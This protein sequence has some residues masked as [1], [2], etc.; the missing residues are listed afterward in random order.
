M[1]NNHIG[2]YIKS[3]GLACEWNF[4]K[5]LKEFDLTSVQLS[6][7][8][9]LVEHKDEVI[10]QKDIENEFCLKNST[11]SGIL[12]RLEAKDYI[13]RET[14]IDDSRYKSITLKEKGLNLNFELI[15]RIDAFEAK[16]LKNFS[17]DEKNHLIDYLIRIYNNARGEEKND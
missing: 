1:R 12:K 15:R 16:L 6:I 4:N 17:D 8:R 3:I 13:K 2:A 9:Y 10:Y 5:D 11:V 7:V 14:G